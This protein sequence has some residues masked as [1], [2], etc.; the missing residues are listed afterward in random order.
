MDFSGWF[1]PRI[2]RLVRWSIA[3]AGAALIVL[4]PFIDEK[5]YPP[6]GRGGAPTT[7]A[8][9]LGAGLL[10]LSCIVVIVAWRTYSP[11]RRRDKN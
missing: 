3:I 10:Y 11:R 6:F 8:V 9:R 1:Y 5:V 2:E 4:L 7:T